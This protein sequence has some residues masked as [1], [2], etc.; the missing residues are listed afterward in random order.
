[1]PSHS[2]ALSRRSW[3]RCFS[4][5]RSSLSGAHLEGIEDYL[6]GIKFSQTRPRTHYAL[7]DVEAAGPAWELKS[8]TMRK[9]YG[10]QVI[11]YRASQQHPE[12]YQFVDDLVGAVEQTRR[13]K[14]VR[15]EGATTP[16][17]RGAL[18]RLVLDNIGPFHHLEL[19]LNPR[20]DCSS[21]RQ[22]RW[23]IEYSQGYCLA[24]CGQDRLSTPTV[25]SR[26]TDQAAAS[27]LRP[28][29]RRFIKQSYLAAPS[30]QS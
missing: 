8:N 26:P 11:P 21:G 4:R 15:A 19:E 9:K 6:T 17:A 29:G 1:M 18:K 30:K 5:A 14:D 27:F 24:V 12:V 25:L 3:R 28:T 23:Q 16:R 10:I 7:V 20:L 13:V 2:I 22:R